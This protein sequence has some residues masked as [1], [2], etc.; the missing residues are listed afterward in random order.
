M[1]HNLVEEFRDSLHTLGFKLERER[2]DCSFKVFG[3]ERDGR[4]M[5][6]LAHE[7]EDIGFG[8]SAGTMFRG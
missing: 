8:E 2:Y 7:S 6:T 5:V 1:A 4:S 3:A